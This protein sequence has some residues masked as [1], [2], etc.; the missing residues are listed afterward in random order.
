ME[1]FDVIIVGAGPAGLS[2]A[3]YT[4]RGNATTCVLNAPMPKIAGEYPIDNYFGFESTIMGSELIA[5]G[6]AQ[7][8]RFG[9]SIRNERVL[10]IY[11]GDEGGFA[12]KTAENTYEAQSVILAPGINLK[13]PNIEGLDAYEGKGI[14]YC[15]SCDAFFF[16][17]KPVAVLG[18][19]DYAVHQAIELR[20]F[21]PHVTL[22]TNGKPHNLSDYFRHKLKEAD[23]PVIEKRIARLSGTPG[24]S[25]L[26][27]DDSSTL[28]VEGLFIAL[29][30]ASASDFAYSLG[31]EQN[32]GHLG[33]N[34][35][36]HTS[37]PGVFAAGDCTGAFPQIAVAVGDGAKAGRAAL[38]YLK[39]TK[40]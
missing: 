30:E 14:S 18:E 3:I 36:Q 16:R 38:K 9:V 25:A 21:T 29:G 17:G 32:K 12:I 34:Q 22:C 27:F 11:Y 6:T 28:D 37:V 8:Q 31:I 19:G 23:I 26:E 1:K 40:K 4:S 7:A 2:A 15:V 24:L 20:G 35:L 5:R 10:T 13:H 39:E 33:V